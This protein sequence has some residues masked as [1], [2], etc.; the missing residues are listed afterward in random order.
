[1]MVDTDAQNS[2]RFSIKEF[3]KDPTAILLLLSVAFTVLSALDV[4]NDLLHAESLRMILWVL[5]FLS[6]V[7]KEKSVLITKYFYLHFAIVLYC[8]VTMAFMSMGQTSE[9]S[10]VIIRLI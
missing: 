1:M 5:L 8:I 6:L 2:D 4:V 9:F 10:T 7:L 3:F